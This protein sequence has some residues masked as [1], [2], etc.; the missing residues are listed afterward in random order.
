MPEAD[1]KTTQ[2]GMKHIPVLY[3]EVLEYLSLPGPV[4]IID[5]TVGSGGHSSL[6][7]G[8]NPQ[9]ALLGIDQD[10]E[11]LTRAGEILAF[12]GTRV[13]LV[14][15]RF[16]QLANLATEF[17][18]DSVDA[19]LLDIGISS[20]QIDDPRRGFSFRLDGPLDMRMDLE[21]PVAAGGII[22]SAPLRELQQ[23]FREYGE[24]ESSRRLAEA[25]IQRRQKRPFATTLDFAQCCEDVLGHSRPGKL[26]T[27]TLCFQALRIAVNDELGELRAALPQAL[28]IVKPGGRIGV[29]TFHSLED[30]M[31]K[32]FFREAARECVCPPGLPVC[33]CCH[34]PELKIL[35]KKPVTA[36]EDE[37]RRNPRSASAKLRVIE[38]I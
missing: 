12:A 3:R 18:W 17:G 26:P 11:A 32:N 20:P 4:R 30:R 28:K 6:I 9:A 5:A 21:S 10:G 29:I 37:L 25:V 38:K 1:F 7:L 16:S 14:R 33:M 34:H 22:N 2:D 19:V 24:I 13:H 15:G 35:T 8:N 31:V 23:I 36:Q 27:P